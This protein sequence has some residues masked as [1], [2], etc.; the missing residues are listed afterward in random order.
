MKKMLT[1]ELPD[2]VYFNCGIS[3]DN[4]YLVADTNDSSNWKTV[5]I[6]LPKGKWIIYSN[7]VGNKIILQNNE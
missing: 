7:P 4:K 6:T 2:G 5:K 1:I 3:S